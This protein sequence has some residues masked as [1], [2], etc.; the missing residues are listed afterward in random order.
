MHQPDSTKYIMLQ[1]L[2]GYESAP[3][4][5]PELEQAAEHAG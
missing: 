1:Y 4:V 5:G 3:A 2:A